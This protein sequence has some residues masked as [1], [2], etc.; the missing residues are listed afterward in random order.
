M[1]NNSTLDLDASDLPFYRHPIVV[2]GV[3]LIKTLIL[4][5]GILAN[6]GVVLTVVFHNC[7]RKHAAFAAASLSVSNIFYALFIL[8]YA[9]PLRFSPSFQVRTTFKQ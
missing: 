2:N 4:S 1:A 7:P 9:T 5:L 8:F 6:L 3:P